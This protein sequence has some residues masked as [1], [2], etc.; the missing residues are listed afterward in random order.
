VDCVDVYLWSGLDVEFGDGQR[1]TFLPVDHDVHGRRNSDQLINSSF[2][3]PSGDHSSFSFIDVVK[4][5][6]SDHVIPGACV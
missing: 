2:V 1:Q 3:P 4:W 6:S 5:R